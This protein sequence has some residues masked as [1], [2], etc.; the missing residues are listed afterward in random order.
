VTMKMAAVVLLVVTSAHPAGAAERPIGLKAAIELAV[1]QNPALAQ[2]GADVEL[3]DAQ[4]E[5]ARGLDDFVLDASGAWSENRS[6][7]VIGQP[8]QAVDDV[9]G[10]VGLTR[11][12]PTGGKLSLRFSEEFLQSGKNP[13]QYAPSLQLVLSHPLLRGVGVSVARAPRRRAR[14]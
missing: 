4:I 1:R 5:S 7:V 8:S 11:P 14:A 2:A 9:V 10:A 3:A 13:D 12:L 6:Q